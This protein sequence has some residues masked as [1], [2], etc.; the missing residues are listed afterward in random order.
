MYAIIHADEVQYK[1]E[2]GLTIRI[3]KKDFEPGT[4]VTIATVAFLSDGQHSLIGKP[5]IDDASVEAEIV[6]HEKGD[7][8]ISFK[9][10]RRKGY[11][12]KIGHRQQYTLLKINKINPPSGIFN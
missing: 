12:R 11:S 4:K 10:R 1:V 7:K 3:D 9:K 6:G 8:V 2:E 5:L